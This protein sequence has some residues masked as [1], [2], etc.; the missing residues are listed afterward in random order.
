MQDDAEFDLL[1][2]RIW[3]LTTLLQNMKHR[4]TPT[5]EINEVPPML[6]HF[7]A[8]L[9]RGRKEDRTVC[10]MTGSATPEGVFA[11][12]VAQNSNDDKKDDGKVAVDLLPVKV[13]P[14]RTF[15]DVVNSGSEVS[16]TNHISDIL[17]AMTTID[18][19][20]GQHL[21]H[22]GS[23]SA[24]IARRNFYKLWTRV[25]QLYKAWDVS[26]IDEWT[27]TIDD[28]PNSKWISVPIWLQ[29]VANH[30]TPHFCLLSACE[31]PD[32]DIL[33]WEFSNRTAKAWA[34]FL[35]SIIQ[36]L[37]NALEKQDT[38]IQETGTQD[39]E[40][41]HKI[42]TCCRFL[43]SYL[44]WK[45]KIVEK[46]LAE[47]T[48]GSV[49]RSPTRENIAVGD[50]ELD[51]LEDELRT[52]PGES[53][54]AFFLRRLR[55]I[56]AWQAAVNFLFSDY[57]PARRYRELARTSPV[58]V[59]VVK[60][61]TPSVPTPI[62]KHDLVKEFKRQFPGSTKILKDLVT[63]LEEHHPSTLSGTVHAEANLLGLA[64]YFT[65]GRCKV[66]YG[67]DF[68]DEKT[69]ER[70]A[71]PAT[72]DG[73]IFVEKKCCWC[74]QRVFKSVGAQLGTSGSGSHGVF[75]SW[76]PPRIGIEVWRLR[77]LEFA[78]WRELRDALAF[79]L[80][81]PSLPTYVNDDGVVVN[82]DDLFAGF[83]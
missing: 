60:M 52:I 46:L 26:V 25:R 78:L 5:S 63:V 20:D 59:A 77:H 76:R 49:L 56:T 27:P 3:T 75:Y 10:A 18:S 62:S 69:F 73:S 6:R 54:G 72:L 37:Y 4:G 48:M 55:T 28:V 9:S 30:D 31:Q 21:D 35:T 53:P 38:T 42:A 50:P 41:A 80:K 13:D 11:M 45:E 64:K 43:H 79:R 39:N 19:M 8:L 22:I 32:S 57:S 61:P 58:F 2:R 17:T 15:E 33:Q 82:D 16:L 12:I 14:K 67:I 66:K 68:K 74:C 71:Q 51:E 47:T 1:E 70:F 44:E 24:F 7:T 40:V 83:D 23:L 65:A 81:S 34:G 36:H 29:T